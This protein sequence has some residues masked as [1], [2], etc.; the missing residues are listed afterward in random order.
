MK[1]KHTH[2]SKSFVKSTELFLNKDPNQD[3]VAHT[4]LNSQHMGGRKIA[5][6]RL[7]WSIVSPG[8]KH[9]KI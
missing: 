4:H 9:T 8:L 3:M 5:S 7:T 2:T 6:L 1:V